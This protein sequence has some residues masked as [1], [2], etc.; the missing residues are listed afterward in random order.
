MCLQNEFKMKAIKKN[1]SATVKPR[2]LEKYQKV[3]TIFFNFRYS[4]WSR[5]ARHAARPA[6]VLGL[7]ADA[8]RPRPPVDG[9]GRGRAP[10][11]HPVRPQRRRGSSQTRRAEQIE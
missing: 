8:E 10:Q 7:A 9:G 4:P 3:R 2:Q 1:Y 11:Q 6:G 5:H